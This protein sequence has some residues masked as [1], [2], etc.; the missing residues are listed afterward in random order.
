MFVSQIR[1][2]INHPPIPLPQ[3]IHNY[4]YIH[5]FC[6][7][8]LRNVMRSA[9]IVCFIFLNLIT[10]MALN[11][12]NKARTSSYVVFLLDPHHFLISLSLEKCNPAFRSQQFWVS[13]ELPI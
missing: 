7:Y 11:E 6:A 8:F 12:I 1:L 3:I 4:V 10:I 9:G 13:P 5:T 2:I